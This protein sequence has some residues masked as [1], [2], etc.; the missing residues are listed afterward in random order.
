MPAPPPWDRRDER[1]PFDLV[2]DVHGCLTELRALL[3]ALGYD[4]DGLHPDGRRLVFLGDLVDRGPDSIGVLELALPW[5]ADGRALVVPGNHDEK[6][7]RWILKRPVRV[8]GGLETTLSEWSRLSG[9]RRARLA[10]GVL[11][12]LWAAPSYLQLDGGGLLAAHAGLPERLHGRLDDEVRSFC[13]RG[14]T[15]GRTVH[16]FPER[17]DWAAGYRGEPWVVHGHVPVL[18][19]CWCN[20]VAD[21]DLGC[22]FGG[23]LAA[24]RWPEREFV[25]VPAERPWW[26][27]HGARRILPDPDALPLRAAE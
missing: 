12:H 17:L 2:G 11:E 6:L 1:G 15:T 3:A 9:P 23:A 24:A 19:A 25:T 10:A 5:I 18:R 27:P 8:Q 14:E 7:A 26:T 20:Q 22:V 4:D 13:L 21:V 16:G